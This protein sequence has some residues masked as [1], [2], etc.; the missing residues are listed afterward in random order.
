MTNPGKGMVSYNPK[1]VCMRMWRV[2]AFCVSVMFL[3]VSV[4][5]AQSAP[6]S[7]A[8]GVFADLTLVS[9]QVDS[10][11]AGQARI[12]SRGYGGLL[13]FGVHLK[14][15]VVAGASGE[16]QYVKD[17]DPFGNDTTGGY[18]TSSTGLY[19]FSIFGGLRTPFL[20]K[21]SGIRLGVNA[22]RSWF[23]GRRSIG[24]C[25]DC[26]EEG[27]NVGGGTYF[28]PLILIGKRQGLNFSASYRIYGK[29]SDV[30]NMFTVGLTVWR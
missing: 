26:D 29:D 1:G 13:G 9:S 18:K 19:D 20:G 22:G 11:A 4:A 8:G 30:R 15:I 16:Y 27:L 25:I 28:E 10:G 2:G 21:T 6:K 3:L 24:N 7:P 12:G 23:G 14:G 5:G 17:K